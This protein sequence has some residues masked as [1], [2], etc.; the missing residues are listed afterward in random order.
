MLKPRLR[1]TPLEDRCTPASFAGNVIT[2]DDGGETLTILTD[3]SGQYTLTSTVDVNESTEPVVFTPD[4]PV[5]VVDAVGSA[6]VLFANSTVAYAHSFSVVLNDGSQGVSFDGSTDFSANNLSVT[7]DRNIAVNAFANVTTSTGNIDFSANMQA[8]ARIGEFIGVDVKGQVTTTGTGNVTVQ[9]RGGLL[10]I[11]GMFGVQVLGSGGGISTDSGTLT[12]TGTGGGG[13]GAANIG[14]HVASGAGIATGSGT[15]NVTGTGGA[16]VGQGNYGVLVQNAGSGITSTGGSINVLGTAGTNGSTSYGV[17]VF[18]NDGASIS[19]GGTGTISVNGIGGGTGTAAFNYGVFVV[20]T[21][22]TI[23][24]TSGGLTVIGTGGGGSGGGGVGVHVAEGGVV[25]S[26]GKIAVNGTGG[27]GSGGDYNVGVMVQGAG[28]AITS[29]GGNTAIDNVV[30]DG[31]AGANGSGYNIGVMAYNGGKISA[32]GTGALVLNGTGKGPNNGRNYGVFI[33]ENGAT[34]S[35]NGIVRLT[36]TA[37]SSGNFTTEAV[38]VS[39][40]GSITSTSNVMVTADAMRIDSNGGSISSGAGTVTIKPRTAGLKTLLGGMETMDTGAVLTLSNFDLGRIQAGT[41]VI[42]STA[43]GSIKFTD[44]VG[45]GFGSPIQNVEFLTGGDITFARDRLVGGATNMLL[46]AAGNIVLPGSTSG[47]YQYNAERVKL[48][49]GSK[50][51]IPINGNL[52]NQSGDFRVGGIADLNNSTLSLTGAYVP[53]PGDVLT[54]V[55]AVERIGSFSNA[56]DN[57]V[58]VFNGVSLRIDYN[59]TSVTATVV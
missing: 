5:S 44:N 13:S 9:G 39:N 8:A 41:I 21:N 43:A 49:D 28:T 20:G 27:A 4:G 26:G 46:K 45:F 36:G 2:L 7:V 59:A 23:T 32:M 47:F 11:Y 38:F 31:T 56:P 6:S 29:V 52:P 22:S 37:P 24:T 51:Q 33:L 40:K 55:L 16:G 30:V 10:N 42:G 12:V 48:A 1:L 57:T 14:V 35:G 18:E 50:V 25:A 15:L 3:T 53:K 17:G 19:T 34:I 54:L 58:M